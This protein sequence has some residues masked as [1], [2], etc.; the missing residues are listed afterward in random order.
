MNV[1]KW[2]Q[3][4]SQKAQEYNIFQC[5]MS[6]GMKEVNPTQVY[7]ISGLSVSLNITMRFKKGS[8]IQVIYLMTC[9]SPRCPL[10]SHYLVCTE[11]HLFIVGIGPILNNRTR[12]FVAIEAIKAKKTFLYKN[13]NFFIAPMATKTS[14]GYIRGLFCHLFSV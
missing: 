5:S 9:S 11:N 10:H 3:Y 14:K 13:P 7:F 2:M 4:I 6:T 8:Q 1:T 12:V